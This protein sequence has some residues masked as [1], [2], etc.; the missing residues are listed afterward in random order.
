MENAA[1][2]ASEIQELRAQLEEAQDTLNAIRR[3]EVDGLV[4]NTAKGEQVYTITGAEKP[5]RIL[6]ENMHEGAVM[7]SDDNTI[8]YCNAGFA[9]MMKYPLEKLNGNNIEKMVSPTFK[10]S[11]KKFLAKCR[12][13][14]QKDAP[15]KEAW[16]TGITFLADDHSLVPTQVSADT[17]SM[18]DTT[19]TF[20]VVTDL[21]KHMEDELKG[22]TADLEKTGQA[23]YESE[24][25]WST[26]LGS[27]GDAVIAT[28]MVGRVTFMNAV[29]EDLTGWSIAEASGKPIQ[30]IFKIIN[31]KSRKSVEDPVSKVISNGKIVGLANHTILIRKDGSEVP[32]DDSGAPIKD[33]NGKIL[34]VVLIF[35][36]IGERRELER[37]IEAYTNN[38]ENIVAE[39]TE[40]L[41]N[42]ERLAAI[43][44]TTGM[45]GHD[46]RNPLQ[47]ITGDLYLANQEI[48]A[49][50][51]CEAKHELKEYCNSIEENVFYIN[52]IVSD[53][54]DFT[55][56]L[57]LNAEHVD[58]MEILGKVIEEAKIPDKIQAQLLVHEKT[59]IDTD[60]AYL[61]RA[62][63]NLIVNA[64]Q[65]MPDGGMLTVEAQQKDGTVEISVKDRG[66]GIPPEIRPNL[67][68]PLFTTKSKGQGLGL[69]V[70]K[71]FID[72]MNGTITYESQVGKGT[73]FTVK[74]PLNNQ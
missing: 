73:T 71:R 18:D 60:P 3:G 72:A 24:Q 10:E 12:G 68:T 17:L 63:T 53:L 36:N 57:K 62:L 58:I 61:R 44:A 43:G 46:I 25:R 9:S 32:I 8:L 20:I 19:T 55:R 27:I 16:T 37:K 15:P 7:L 41:K 4:V 47:A 69:A 28:D 66:V 33:K 52:K 42:A 45:V 13:V 74:L 39:R 48:E 70:V 11:F 29:A 14:A 30:E 5:Y 23:L 1:N 21:T 65:A 38:L 49:L 26:T 59:V 34:G 22:Y 31:E 6:I 40:K 50:P 35:R 51:D 67:F 2:E 56:T 64:I 54:Q